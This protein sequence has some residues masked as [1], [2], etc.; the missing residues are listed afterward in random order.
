MKSYVVK[1][2]VNICSH[3]TIFMHIKKGNLMNTF[4]FFFE[5]NCLRDHQNFF[6]VYNAILF[7]VVFPC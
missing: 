3:N 4:F 2:S 5:E 1:F 6:L 7:I